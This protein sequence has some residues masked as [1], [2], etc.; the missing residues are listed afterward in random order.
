MTRRDPFN[1]KLTPGERLL[2][3]ALCAVMAVII[4]GVVFGIAML[5]LLGM[6]G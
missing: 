5:A 4:G 1:E 3:Y 6:A 2:D